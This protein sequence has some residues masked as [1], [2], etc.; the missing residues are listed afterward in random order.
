[1]QIA[2]ARKAYYW[3]G[4]LHVHNADRMRLVGQF[5]PRRADTCRV[6]VLGDSLT[7][8]KGV[9]EEDTYCRLLERQLGQQYRVEVLNLGR[10]GDQSEDM[11]R[12]LRAQFP[13]LQPDLVVYGVCLND[14]LP[15]G[16]DQYDNNMAWQIRFP[17]R[18]HLLG[19]TEVGPFLARKYD[20]LL[21]YWGVRADFWHDILRDFRGYQK[22]FARDVRELNAYVRARGLPPVVAM[23]LCQEPGHGLQ[24]G[25]TAVAEKYL[26]DAGMDVVPAGYIREYAG[27]T[28]RVSPWEGHPNEKAHAVYAEYLRRYLEKAPVLQKYR[29]EP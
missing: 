13:A 9:A 1:V 3:H 16:V 22:R 17:G 26:R 19:A 28:W 4:K 24:T 5:P 23:V 21:R 7:Y 10:C 12:T 14:F 27:Q 6:M 25:L 20:E 11:V 18:D 29:N 2:G 8:G 15:S